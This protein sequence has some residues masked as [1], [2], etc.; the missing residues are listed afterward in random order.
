MKQLLLAL[1]IPLGAFSRTAA[2]KIDGEEVYRNNCTRCHIAFQ[3]VSARAL[4][5]AVHHMQVRALL[6]RD[7]QRAV[8]NYLLETATPADHKRS[9]KVEAKKP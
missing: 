8:L 7:E 2:R 4:P 1:L 5:A 9:Q 3:R 6:T